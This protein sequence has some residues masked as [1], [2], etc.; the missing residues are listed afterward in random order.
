MTAESWCS[1]TLLM[2]VATETAHCDCERLGLVVFK[3]V[4][5]GKVGSY[6]NGMNIVQHESI[7]Y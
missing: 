4:W 6:P 7:E 5:K 2:N 1:R 3:D